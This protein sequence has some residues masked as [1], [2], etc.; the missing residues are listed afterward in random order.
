MK[1]SLTMITYI[2]IVSQENRENHRLETMGPKPWIQH[3]ES[4]TM[5][6]DYSRSLMKSLFYFILLFGSTMLFCDVTCQL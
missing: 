5:G 4:K 2:Y 6:V 1:I 3:N